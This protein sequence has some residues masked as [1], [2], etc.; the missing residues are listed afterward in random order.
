MSLWFLLSTLVWGP[1]SVLLTVVL[2]LRLSVCIWCYLWDLQHCSTDLTGKTAV[3]TGANSG[4]GKSVS[5]EL[6]HCGVH[7]ILACCSHE[8]GQ[9]ALAQIRAA[10]QSNQL[11]LGEVDVSSMASIRSFAQWLLRE[12]PEIHLLV[13]NAAVCGLPT[14]RT[15]EGL[16]VTFATNY[17]GPFLLTNLLQAAPISRAPFAP[18]PV[19]VPALTL[20][21][22]DQPPARL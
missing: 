18:V 14:T 20:L 19:S 8:R 7:M 11:L 13:N 9:Q 17:I 16:D 3:V 5:Q 10:S 6:A 22:E 12:H 21:H 2:L 4:V 1:G 15:P